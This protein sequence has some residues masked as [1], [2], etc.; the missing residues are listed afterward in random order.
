MTEE[1]EFKQKMTVGEVTR[2]FGGLQVRLQGELQST[3]IDIRSD[4]PFVLGDRIWLLEI[5]K[6]Q[7]VAMGQVKT[8]TDYFP[9]PIETGAKQVKVSV[10]TI[11]GKKE[12]VTRPVNPDNSLGP[13]KTVP[14]DGGTINPAE[15]SGG[16]E[17]VGSP[18]VGRVLTLRVTAP[19]TR[20]DGSQVPGPQITFTWSVNLT[21]VENYNENT[22][23]LTNEHLN[24][25]IRVRASFVNID[26]TTYSTSDSVGPVTVRVDNNPPTGSISI[27]GTIEEE[28]I[29]I[30]N[31][32]VTD[33]DGINQT[34]RVIAWR[35][36]GTVIATGSDRVRIPANTAGQELTASFS[37]SDSLGNPYVFTATPQT[38]NPRPVT[39][40]PIDPEEPP[41][42]P[43][44]PTALT[45][46]VSSVTATSALVTVS[47]ALPNTAVTLRR[48]DGFSVTA[49][50]NANGVRTFRMTGL[51][52]GQRY[53]ATLSSS[54][55]TAVTVSWT[56][57]QDLEIVSFEVSNRGQNSATVIAVLRRVPREGG[58]AIFRLGSVI[59][60]EVGRKRFQRGIRETTISFTYPNLLPNLSYTG[61]LVIGNLSR[62]VEIPNADI[63]TLSPIRVLN[64]TR[65]SIEVTTQIIDGFTLGDRIRISYRELGDS[66]WNSVLISRSNTIRAKF[67][68]PKPLTNYEVRAEVIKGRFRII[69]ITTKTVTVRTGK[70]T[71]SDVAAVRQWVNELEGLSRA[72]DNLISKLR[73]LERTLINARDHF[74]NAANTISTIHAIRQIRDGE[75]DVK[76]AERVGTEIKELQ[77]Q[78]KDAQAKFVALTAAIFGLAGGTLLATGILSVT[79]SGA[80]STIAVGSVT[81]GFGLGATSG[82]GIVTIAGVTKGAGIGFGLLPSLGGF[83]LFGGVLIAVLGILITLAGAIALPFIKRESRKVSRELDKA[84]EGVR[85]DIREILQ[86]PS[87]PVRIDND[88]IKAKELLRALEEESRTP[89]N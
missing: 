85:Q 43:P 62:S 55:R 51:T 7:W 73:E 60:I 78:V 9:E 16:I 35:L 36:D 3:S 26:G 64:V 80:L 70:A 50:S 24:A 75:S 52:S 22:F 18:I 27:T 67:S 89:M 42:P 10:E 40:P 34:T 86:S 81:V 49:S 32:T 68:V 28:S 59:G 11:G 5:H 19:F 21:R 79:V 8:E 65:S 53:S 12:I 30:L 39:P 56:A 82:V 74:T 58:L 17:I 33:P 2:I 48:S 54:G 37:F 41:P 29:A 69:P 88:L 84:I 1:N 31:N 46:R 87:S 63:P 47:N 77:Q 66:E 38:V 83:A 13:K 72:S 45:A 61:F 23:T 4:E 14:R 57:S 15:P 25:T 71:A 6:G 76:R 44:D 20:S